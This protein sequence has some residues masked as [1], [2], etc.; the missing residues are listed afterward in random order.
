MVTLITRALHTTADFP[1]ILGDAVNRELRRSYQVLVSGARLLARQTTA[2]D[3]RAN[4]RVVLGE[5]PS[6]K[7]FLRA[8]NSARHHQRSRQNVRCDHFRQDHR[9]QSSGAGE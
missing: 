3:L 1:L 5:A 9:H 4:R 6:W 7:R 2:R 8:R